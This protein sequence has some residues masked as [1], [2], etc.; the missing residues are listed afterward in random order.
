[1]ST[2]NWDKFIKQAEEAGESIDDYTPIPAGTYEAKVFK[3]EVKKFKG[4]TKEGWN[5]SFVIE[6][7]P[8]SGRRVFTNLVISPESSKAMSILIKQLGAL[9][10]KPLLEAGASNEQIAAAMKD[11]P[12]TLKVSVGTWNDKPK[13]DVDSIAP[14]QVGLGGPNTQAGLGLPAAPAGLPI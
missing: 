6:G 14:R 5:I 13:N 1:M 10:V 11:A 9:G 12:V 4:N 3:A 8:H 7:G 2:I